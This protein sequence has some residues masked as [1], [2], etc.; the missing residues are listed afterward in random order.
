MFVVVRVDQLHVHADAIADP[1][2]T[3]LQKRGHAQGFP[4]FAGVPHG[5]APIRHDG[6]T[7]DHLQ[8]SNL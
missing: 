3:A 5:I 6:H 1:S 7:R 4:Y 8:L 2:D